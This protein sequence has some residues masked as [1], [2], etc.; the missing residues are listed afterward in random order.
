MRRS[1]GRITRGGVAA[2]MACS[3][4]LAG[5]GVLAAADQGTLPPAALDLLTLLQDRSPGA[6]ASGQLAQTKPVRVEQPFERVLPTLRTPGTAAA[7]AATAVPV[8]PVPPQLTAEL[9][10]T[11]IAYGPLGDFQPVP[12]VAGG[13]VGSAP[14]AGG[15]TPIG[16]I[17]V[18]PAPVESPTP[19]PSPSPV[20]VAPAVPE[21]SPWAMLLL[22][23]WG[24]GVALRRRDRMAQLFSEAAAGRSRGDR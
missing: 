17:P 13:P 9:P 8:A 6:R 16:G 5:F 14:F 23:F 19:A 12:A 15:V 4:V 22:G 10:A 11:P 21:P 18:S 3:T 7:P 2:I 20:E 24:V 1:R